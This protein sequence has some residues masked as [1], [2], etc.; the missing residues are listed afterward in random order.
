MERAP[1]A[2]HVARSISR[3]LRERAALLGA[4]PARERATRS[5]PCYMGHVALHLA[6]RIALR[7][8]LHLALQVA[9]SRSAPGSAPL[10]LGARLRF[11]SRS[12]SRSGPGSGR[13][14][15]GSAP[16]PGARYAGPPSLPA[17]TSSISHPHSSPSLPLHRRAKSRFISQITPGLFPAIGRT[18][19]SP[20][21]SI[22]RDLSRHRR[23]H[24]RIQRLFPSRA[25]LQRSDRRPQTADRSPQTARCRLQAARCKPQ[26]PDPRPQTPEPRAQ[27]PAKLTL[28]WT[29]R[30]G[31]PAG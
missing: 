12:R 16:W 8:A 24:H 31:I 1:G 17:R 10:S 26:T 29:P 7:V 13:S 30:N 6:L 14:P 4:L 19:P 15:A 3:F 25:G 5:A 11:R 2:L 18:A 9:R 23:A 22:G 27:T 28:S 21:D 20:S